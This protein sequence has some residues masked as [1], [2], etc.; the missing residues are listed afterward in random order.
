MGETEPLEHTRPL[1]VVPEASAVKDTK[2]FPTARFRMWLMALALILGVGSLGL[3]FGLSIHERKAHDAYLSA[4]IES[5][6]TAPAETAT[7]ANGAQQTRQSQP[8]QQSKVAGQSQSSQQTENATQSVVLRVVQAPTTYGI[9]EP[10]EELP[11]TVTASIP[12]QW[13][14]KAGAYGTEGI[15]VLGPVG[16]TGSA[17]VGANGNVSMTLSG[18]L[19]VEKLVVIPA[20]SGSAWECAAPYFPKLRKEWATYWSGTEP[21]PPPPGLQ[22]Y[23]INPNLVAYSIPA[24]GDNVT[25]GVTFASDWLLGKGG[26]PIPFAAADFLITLPSKDKSLATLILNDFIR[27][28]IKGRK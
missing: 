1:P 16:W 17:S 11:S 26:N 22:E 18:P 14:G 20:S 7:Q 12:R 9:G 4:Q 15:V 25:H 19:G 21:P 6:S 2:P 8:Q 27:R 10:S 13:V 3:I 5:R 28:N 24:S 23:W